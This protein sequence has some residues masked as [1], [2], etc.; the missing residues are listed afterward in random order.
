MAYIQAAAIITRIRE[1]LEDGR[2]DLRT[3]TAGRFAGDLP[4]GL[5][6]D[7]EHMRTVTGARCSADIT[8]I[9]PSPASPPI[10][11]NLILY[12]IDVRVRVIRLITALEQTDDASHD[13]LRALAISDVD[14]VRQ[15]LE[16]PNNLAATEAGAT[17]DLVSGLLRYTGATQVVVGE[18]DSG[19]QTLETVHD[20]TGTAISRPATS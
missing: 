19:A 20:F 17:C 2:G 15:A 16:Y 18:I 9:R 5:S 7:A 14:I 1:V 11:G 4:E 3:V 6:I 13:A 10:L 12:E 8:A